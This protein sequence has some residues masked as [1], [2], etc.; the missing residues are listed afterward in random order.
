MAGEA[1]SRA[2]AARIGR[3][4]GDGS[5][6]ALIRIDSSMIEKNPSGVVW[7]SP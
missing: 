2:R 4:R 5:K 7:R 1:R 3:M 6:L